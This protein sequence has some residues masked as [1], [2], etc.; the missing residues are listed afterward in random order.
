MNLETLINW[1]VLLLAITFLSAHFS[2][3]A[4]WLNKPGV[5]K[6]TLLLFGLFILLTL[7]FFLITPIRKSN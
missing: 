2:V 5:A 3:L 4:Y 7:A 6:I 1:R